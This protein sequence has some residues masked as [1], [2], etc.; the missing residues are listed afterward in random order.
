MMTHREVQQIYAAARKEGVSLRSHG[1]KLQTVSRKAILCD[2]IG[3][4]YSLYNRTEYNFIPEQLALNIAVMDI[5]GK[6][7]SLIRTMGSRV[8]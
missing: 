2:L 1:L 4:S 8:L 6:L 5:I 7:T 3:M